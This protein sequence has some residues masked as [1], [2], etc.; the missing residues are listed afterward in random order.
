MIRDIMNAAASKVLLSNGQ[1]ENRHK[2]EECYLFGNG[3][4]IK[5]F[6]LSKFSDKI[7]FGCNKLDVHK[8]ISKLNLKYYISTHP[9][10]YS[11]YWRGVKSGFHIE[12]NPFYD[13]VHSHSSDD[14]QVFV[15]ASNYPFAKKYDNFHYVHNFKRN[16]L[17]LDT[18]D[19]SSS[20]SFTTGGLV[21]M[22]GLAIY[23]GFKKIYLVGCDYWFSTRGQ[24]HFYSIDDYLEKEGDFLYKE[25]IQVISNEVEI[26][27]VTRNGVKSPVNYVEY[28]E[29]T[30]ADEKKKSATDI[31]SEEDLKFLATTMYLRGK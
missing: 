28:S 21:T 10:L 19:F 25:L 12:R 5:Y 2:G 3:A 26:V 29:L 8:D 11:K 22:I 15:H 20:S 31:V 1:F 30:G 16:K 17:S 24:G 23:M 14:Y 13:S 27:V 9:L 6:D 7:S 18:L 4:S